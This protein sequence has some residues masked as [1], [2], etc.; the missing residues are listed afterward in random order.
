MNGKLKA[1][2]AHAGSETGKALC[3]F[4]KDYDYEIEEVTSS[5]ERAAEVILEKSP[6]LVITDVY[7]QD[8]DA[9]GMLE[10]LENSGYGGKTVFTV[11]TSVNNPAVTNDLL[12]RGIDMFTL[13]PF[14]RD[15][16]DRKIRNLHNR[17]IKA[18]TPAP[19]HAV[20]DMDGEFELLSYIAK[21]LHDVGVPASIRGYDYIREAIIM[22]LSDKEI[23]K[24][25]TKDLYPTIAKNNKTTASRVERAIRHAVEVAWQRG[26]VETI[27]SI[28][29]Y[30]VKASKG[31]PTNGEFI[32]ILVERIRLDM[33]I[34]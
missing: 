18:E 33:K 24:S 13:I 7:L 32:S 16:T 29:G 23:L 21:V 19:M 17:K 12:A 27:N 26:D 6:D 9:C 28:F 8:V 15:Y 30:T 2:L 34:L 25:I 4:L 5:G 20:S 3:E 22:G 31:K 1:V 14:N 10:Q 11:A